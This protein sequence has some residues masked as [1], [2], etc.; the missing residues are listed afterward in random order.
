MVT[1]RRAADGSAPGELVEWHDDPSSRPIA[2]LLAHDETGRWVVLQANDGR[3]MLRDVLRGTEEDLAPWQLDLRDDTLAY[4]GHRSLALRAG[5]FAAL[6]R[7]GAVAS[8]LLRHLPTG[9]ERRV[10]V[11]TGEP[12]RLTLSPDA[13][14]VELDVVVS[15]D[16][17][18]G[19][20]DWPSAP[21]RAPREA[22]SPDPP[23]FQ[24]P[25]G[26]RDRRERRLVAVESEE[27]AVT[28]PG[29][30]LPWVDGWLARGSGGEVTRGSTPGGPPTTEL[31]P[32]GCAARVLAA[33]A[34]HGTVLGTCTRERG[35]PE[36]TLWS[37]AGLA[38]LGATLGSLP[39]DATEAADVRLFAMLAGAEPI[40]VDL[41]RGDLT[42]FA[43]EDVVRAVAGARVL[44]QRGD[45]LAVWDAESGERRALAG[46]A[47]TLPDVIERGGF[48]VVTPWLVSLDPPRVLGRVTSRPLALALD[49]SVL[50]GSAPAPLDDVMAPLQWVRLDPVPALDDGGPGR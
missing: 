42:R 39:G 4:A 41:G 3:T 15:D 22:C 27:G 13:R 2:A 48:A 40:V 33:S 36:L 24:T 35:R 23:R 11:G 25:R 8:L 14:W 17:G 30:V 5:W 20:L 31:F 18:N 9:R 32:G 21:A 7:E 26:G 49:G 43:R 44:L 50:L 38:P 1:C 37:A 29:L 12:W 6:R 28:V 19:R 45:A 34:T 46:G 10:A 47:D 16:D